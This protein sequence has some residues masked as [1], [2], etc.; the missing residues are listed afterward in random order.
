MSDTKVSSTTKAVWALAIFTIVVS[1]IL[2]FRTSDALETAAFAKKAAS[3]ASAASTEATMRAEDANTR[4]TVAR[5]MATAI[6]LEGD[7]PE[8]TNTNEVMKMDK[9]ERAV[10]D[11]VK[12]KKE[13]EAAEKAA[14]E[15]RLAS[16]DKKLSGHDDQIKMLLEDDEAIRGILTNQTTQIKSLQQRAEASEE[17]ESQFDGKVQLAMRNN[18]LALDGLSNKVAGLQAGKVKVQKTGK[19]NAV[20]QPGTISSTTISTVSGIIQR[21]GHPLIKSGWFSKTKPTTVSYEI[22]LTA[23]N[24]TSSGIG[25]AEFQNFES[26]NPGIM[27]DLAGIDEKDGKKMAKINANLTQAFKDYLGHTKILPAEVKFVGARAK[28]TPKTP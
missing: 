24:G 22:T 1:V 13:R 17:F 26:K 12:A 10:R 7:M 25:E 21:T 27:K 28:T 5:N 8:P 14:L 4:A 9:K 11:M 20:T 19:T 6:A 15:V 3:D 16:L 18:T 23:P 2:F